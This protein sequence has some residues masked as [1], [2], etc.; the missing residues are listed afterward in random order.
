MEV[1]GRGGARRQ[2]ES[3]VD[4]C[5]ECQTAASARAEREPVHLGPCQAHPGSDSPCEC[6][7]VCGLAQFF[8]SLFISHYPL[9][10]LD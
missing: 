3:S 1:G 5:G 9:F 10:F 6:K 2:R 7:S 8:A 4:R